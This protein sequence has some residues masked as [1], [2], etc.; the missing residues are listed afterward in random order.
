MD[1]GLNIPTKA[2]SWKVVKR[3]EELGFSHAWFF[4]TPL[5]NAEP[6]VAMGAAAV[7]TSKIKLCTGVLIPSNRLAPVTASGL[8][9]LNALAPGRIVF[10][11]STGFTGRRAMG[12]G[13]ITL[14]Q[15]EK[16]IEMVDDLLK[17][18]II[19][20]AEGE[21]GESRKITF[22]NP[23]LELINIKDRIPLF[24][25]AFG[26]KSRALTAKHGAGWMTGSSNPSR[27]KAEL[28][29]FR[30]AWI[31]NNRDPKDIYISLGVNGCVLGEGEPADSPRSLAQA[32]PSAAIA[33][34]NLVEIEQFGSITPGAPNFRF[35]A[36]LEAYRRVYETY[37]PSDARYISN[38]KGHLMFVRPEEKHITA[39][40]IRGLT[41]TGTLP[42]IVERVR[43]IK[44]SGYQQ[45]RFNTVPGHEEDMLNHWADVMA[46]V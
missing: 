28:D 7:K 34:H 17:G 40:V 8:A 26:P 36:E 24:I 46:K 27:E 35:P 39:N 14:A 11:V 20:W 42:E 19:D 25:S 16:Y 4:D 3:A 23:E 6:F 44:A 2:A 37:E 10:G 1:F 45:V 41:T 43:G 29:D 15:M 5:I 38:H 30:A 21:D 32:G 9:T 33:F 12:L 22:L 31:A 18:K 13:A